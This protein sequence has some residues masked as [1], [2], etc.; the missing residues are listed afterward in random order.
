[1]AIFFLEYYMMYRLWLCK[2]KFCYNLF[3]V[4]PIL[5]LDWLDYIGCTVLN[6]IG[7]CLNVFLLSRKGLSVA[8][9]ATLSLYRT[10]KIDGITAIVEHNFKLHT[11]SDVTRPLFRVL[12]PLKLNGMHQTLC[13]WVPF[14][15]MFHQIH[16]CLSGGPANNILGVM[17][18]IALCGA[19]NALNIFAVTLNLAHRLAVFFVP[20]KFPL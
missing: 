20:W 18:V 12:D 19:G 13:L 14:T 3:Q 11:F 1:M 5:T 10:C 17:K 8:Q 16:G 7:L 9:N 2:K 6:S 4:H 15:I